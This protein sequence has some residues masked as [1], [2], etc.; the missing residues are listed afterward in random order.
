ML[1]GE[2]AGGESAGGESVK[3]ILAN[4]PQ[5]NPLPFS[6]DILQSEQSGLTGNGLVNFKQVLNN[7]NCANT[8]CL[9]KVPAVDIKAYTEK[10]GL[11]FPP[12]NGDGTA[13]SDVRDSIRSGKWPK[14]PVMLGS[15]L[16]EASVYLAIAGVQDG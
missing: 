16:K 3:Q 7:F 2:S 10:Q 9:R 11:A 15:N 13:L 12:V 6:P 1:F 14:I 8:N 5:T 4:P